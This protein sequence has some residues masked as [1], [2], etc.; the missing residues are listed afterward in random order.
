MAHTA[1]IQSLRVSFLVTVHAQS[2]RRAGYKTSSIRVLVADGALKIGLKMH[3][4]R[5]VHLVFENIGKRRP[6]IVQSGMADRARSGILRVRLIR[7][8]VA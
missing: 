6:E 1:F 3:R 5:K 7:N 8:I 2:L 4:V